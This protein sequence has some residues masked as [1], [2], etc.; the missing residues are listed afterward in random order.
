L[1]EDDAGSYV[2]R[3]LLGQRLKELRKES[4]VPT[5]HAS[6]EVGIARGTLWRMEKGGVKCRYKPGDIE[7]LGRVYGADAE[8]I[9]ILVGLAR[10][11]KNKSWFSSYRDVLPANFEMYVDLEA[12]ANRIRWYEPELVPGLLQT[13][14]YAAYAIGSRL[15]LTN[16]EVRK[17]TQVRM[18]RQKLL[19]RIRPHTTSFE[20][21]LGEGILMRPVS[22]PAFM[23]EQLRHISK[24]S[25]R[26]NVS[27]RMVTFG[28]GMHLGVETGAFEILGFPKNPQLGSPPTTVYIDQ[29]AGNLFLDKPK[30]IEPYEETFNDLLNRALDEAE[31]RDRIDEA[32]RR[33]DQQ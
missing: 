10:T 13:E 18:K 25:E 31:S 2:P 14:D 29:V 8:T 27:I 6:E 28:A 26:T 24:I 20:F 3:L 12:Y 33:F 5:E 30:E 21:V 1:T 7:M 4:G 15:R 22:S 19:T 17:R 32:A 23:A 11:I 9:D 16:A